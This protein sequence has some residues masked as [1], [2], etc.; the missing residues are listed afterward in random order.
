MEESIDGSDDDDGDVDGVYRQVTRLGGDDPSDDPM[1]T[2]T[3]DGR[4][5]GRA[6]KFAAESCSQVQVATC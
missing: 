1:P 5:D 2:V 6:S 3:A 4:P